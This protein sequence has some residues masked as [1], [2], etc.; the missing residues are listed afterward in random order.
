MGAV[1]RRQPPGSEAVAKGIA[2]RTALVHVLA[3]WTAFVIGRLDN[4]ALGLIS[5]SLVISYALQSSSRPFWRRLA[6]L[7]GALLAAIVLA[8]L[9]IRS[10]VRGNIAY[11]L[12]LLLAMIALLF[13]T[14]DRRAFVTRVVARTLV[15]L[16]PFTAAIVAGNWWLSRSNVRDI[17]RLEPIAGSSGPDAY[18]KG[19]LPKWTLKPGFKGRFV[20][21]QYDAELFEVN[22]D[23]YRDRPWPDH[24]EEDRL[25]VL[26]FGDSMVVGLGVEREETFCALLEERLSAALGTPVRTFN[27]AVSGYGPA[28]QL[29]ILDGLLER[30]DPHVVLA[31]F[32]DGND[33]EDLRAALDRERGAKRLKLEL[34]SDTRTREINLS[35]ASLMTPPSGLLDRKFWVSVPA[36]A[37]AI[38]RIEQLMVKAGLRAR[39][40]RTSVWQLRALAR[41]PDLVISEMVALSLAC[42]G[43][44][45]DKCNAR[46]TTLVMLRIPCRWQT[47]DALFEEIFRSVGVDDPSAFARQGSGAVILARSAQA[48]RPVI[49]ALP[50]MEAEARPEDCFFPEGHLSRR[51]HV[52]VADLLVRSARIFRDANRRH[53]Q[54]AAR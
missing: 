10:P 30:L 25:R 34:P 51:G 33:L 19:T 16:I 20:H 41:K 18:V 29:V 32:Y 11:V 7:P 49:D 4:V 21:P 31:T 3:L 22:A 1:P 45:A 28:E 47:S 26:V 6:P 43:V 24:P 54:V 12:A 9:V 40:H 39:Q 50:A 17:Y 36:M 13:A 46:G 14:F 23:G 38:E 8:H 48:G 35:N 2:M 44:M 37:F 15:V 5:A 53:A 42:F 27:A 52:V